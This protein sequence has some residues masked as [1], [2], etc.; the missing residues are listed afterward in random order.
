M[1][2]RTGCCLIGGS[3]RVQ[4]RTCRRQQGRCGTP[5][6]S[7]DLDES[8]TICYQLSLDDYCNQVVGACRGA[9]Q[10]ALPAAVHVLAL[11]M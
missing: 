1:P 4:A 2:S 3:E 5:D 9:S 8:A 6:S 11:F 7:L 10:L